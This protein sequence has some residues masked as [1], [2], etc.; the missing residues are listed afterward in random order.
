MIKSRIIA[1]NQVWYDSFY[2]DTPIA[3]YQ[4]SFLM[5]NKDSSFLWYRLY[6]HF[7][8]ATDNVL[9]V[10]TTETKQRIL[11]KHHAEIQDPSASSGQNISIKWMNA[12]IHL[13]YRLKK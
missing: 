2:I 3:T 1:Y 5:R 13:S 6:P 10:Q 11:K 9:I 12:S 4:P 8:Q 7:I